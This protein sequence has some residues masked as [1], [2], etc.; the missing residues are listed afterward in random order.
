MDHFK[1]SPPGGKKEFVAMV[2]VPTP[3]VSADTEWSPLRSVIVG[4]AADSCFP[5]AP[6]HM[7]KATMP[8]AHIA[9]FHPKNCFP[10]TIIDRADAELRQ[11]AQILRDHSVL[12]YRPE[13]ID[14]YAEGDYTAVMPREGLLIAGNTVIE[15][16]FAWEC[17]HRESELAISGILAVL[18]K[19]P[20]V[21]VV[22][23]RKVERPEALYEGV[24]GLGK[25]RW[26]MVRSMGLMA[27]IRM[28]ERSEIHVRNLMQL[29]SCGLA[30]RLW[31]S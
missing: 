26:R 18:E 2:N 24:E 6:P 10:A 13:A 28:N 5:R 30:R 23:A 9:S 11:F 16:C 3:L 14:W 15:T 25:R 1:A 20:A 12:V 19:D 21:T 7:I 22:R 31:G 4:H 17:R 29:I 8:E 27:C